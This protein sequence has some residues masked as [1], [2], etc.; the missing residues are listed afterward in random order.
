MTKRSMVIFCLFLL[1]PAFA[2][3]VEAG[4]LVPCKGPDCQACHLMELGRRLLNWLITISIVIIGVIAAWAGFKMVTSAGNPGGVSQAKGMFTNA[5]IGLLILLSSWLII[6]TVMK[7]LTYQ[8]GT[9]NGVEFGPWNELK[10]VLQQSGTDTSG[11]ARASAVSTAPAAECLTCATI[12]SNLP[13]NG[14]ACSGGG[15]CQMNATMAERLT[16]VQGSVGDWRVSEAW[17]PAGY[18]PQKPSGIHAEACHGTATCV[19]VSFNPGTSITGAAVNSFQTSAATNNL[20]AVYEVPTQARATELRS[21]GAQNVIVVQG[22]N[23][24]HFSVYMCDVDGSPKQC[25]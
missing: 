7:Q 25:K 12:P 8:S 4:E 20:K 21:Q 17:P 18:T 19:D 16:A 6:D 14:N 10:C 24:E 1:V 13:T 5:L 3:A 2:L 11:A 23:R 22:I 9:V 15:S